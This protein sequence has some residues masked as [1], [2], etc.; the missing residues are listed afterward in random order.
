MSAVQVSAADTDADPGLV[1]ASAPALLAEIAPGVSETLVNYDG[2]VARVWTK[3]TGPTVGVL[4]GPLGVPR[5]N[6]Y[7]EQLSA[8]YRVVVPSLPGFPGGGMSYERLDSVADWVIATLDLLDATG[9]DGADLIGHSIGGALLAEVA[10][11]S[12]ASVARM[13]LVAPYGLYDEAAPPANLWAMRSAQ[14]NPAMSTV[15]ERIAEQI[16]TPEHGDLVEWPI[17]MQR[18]VVSGAR[19]FWPLCDL[20]LHKRLHRITTPTTLIWGGA[21]AALASTYAQLFADGMGAAT[22][23]IELI[24]GAGHLV[25]LDAP[26]ALVAAIRASLT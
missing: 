17:Q 20:G 18:A 25:D 8:S 3:G 11:F 12:R 13:V 24:E 14:A 22:T 9:L 23:A 5:W 2:H 6:D 26:A 1:T 21:D 16:A 19:L 4:A 7:L 10:A 15:P